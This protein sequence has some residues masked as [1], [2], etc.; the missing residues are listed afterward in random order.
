[1]KDVVTISDVTR[2]HGANVCVA[3]YGSNGLCIRLEFPFGRI[4]EDWLYLDGTVVRPFCRL[5][6]DLIKNVPHPPHTEDWIVEPGHV[7]FRG[8]LTNDEREIF[9]NTF[10]DDAVE[11]IFSTP[12]KIGPGWYVDAGEGNRS[13]GTILIDRLWEVIYDCNEYGK[14]NYRIAFSDRAGQRYRLMVT[15]LTFR[16]CL[17]YMRDR[18]DNPQD[19]AL[20]LTAF[21]Q[22]SKTYLRIGLSRGWDKF[23]D[24]CYLQINGIHSFPD[25]LKGRCFTDFITPPAD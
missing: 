8:L 22:R 3:G 5:E 23:P 12:I 20:K 21:L 4:T 14:W 13:L 16:Y 2:M 11:Q 25:Y 6:M 17:D 10:A 24:R 7:A 1:M 15:D 19:L 9:L 18:G